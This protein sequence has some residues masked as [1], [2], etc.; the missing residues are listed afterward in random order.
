M[1]KA[2]RLSRIT[3]TLPAA[4]VRAADRLAAQLNR[5]RSW[6]VAEGLRRWVEGQ[7]GQGTKGRVREPA[8]APYPAVSGLG[9]YRLEQL[10]ADL[11]LTPEERVKAAAEQVRLANRLRPHSRTYRIL[12]FD[13]YEDYADWKGREGVIW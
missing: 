1:T 4:L 2:S 10:R 5:S 7:G 9:E 13:S 8:H 3:I 6:V 12:A 11:R